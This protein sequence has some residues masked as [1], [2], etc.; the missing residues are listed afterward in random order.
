MATND[1]AYREAMRAMRNAA[2]MISD[3]E[4]RFAAMTAAM[5]AFSSRMGTDEA[6]MASALSRL[7]ILEGNDA[8]AIA[9]MNAIAAAMST[10]TGRVSSEETMTA[11]HTSQIAAL[12]AN[13]LN[14][15]ILPD[16]NVVIA[17]GLLSILAAGARTYTVNL[18]ASLGIK[19]GDPIFVSP[20][21]AVPLGYLVGAASA[22]ADN[23]L[24]VQILNPLLNIGA[25]FSINLTVFTLRP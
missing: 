2:S 6:A 23:S 25:S 1:Q 12:N 3:V 13:K 9:S 8:A 14:R 11:T 16:W 21:I 20:K 22:P 17:N 4:T 19:A 15:L 10:L 18:S 24:Q 5:D 7:G